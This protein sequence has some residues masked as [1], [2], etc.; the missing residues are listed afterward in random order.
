MIYTSYYSNYRNFPDNFEPVSVSLYPPKGFKGMIISE[1]VPTDSIL[2]DFKDKKIDEFDYIKRYYDEVLLKLNPHQIAKKLEN[3]I[4]LCFEKRGDFCHRHII[5][6]WLK[7]NGYNIKELDNNN[8]SIRIAV[9]GSRDF[10]NYRTAFKLL[11]RLSNKYNKNIKIVSGGAN[12]ADKIAE[13]YAQYRGL[14]IDIFPADWKKYGKSAGFK[15]N[16]EIW[17]NADIGIAFW[18]NWSKGTMHSFQISFEQ[19]KELYIWNDDLKSFTPRII[20]GNV[21]QHRNKYKLIIFTANS[22]INKNKLV[23]GAGCAKAFKQ[24]FEGLDLKFAEKI[25]NLTFFGFESIKMNNITIGAFQTKIN[26]QDNSS[27]ELIKKSLERLK[28]YIKKNNLQ[29]EKI[30]MCFPG[31]G[32]GGLDKKDVYNIF[33][34]FGN[35]D[36]FN[37]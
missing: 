31:I 1:L 34:G 26:Y 20:K 9:I 3:K 36:L 22:V 17:D 35:I 30:A 8:K 29:K 15:R 37:I 28:D 6:E 12:G 16:I 18:K 24:E 27:I 10:N 4:L 32:L 13:K 25:D 14:D 23:M 7:N 33:S 2:K 11:D 19:N 21:L 5:A